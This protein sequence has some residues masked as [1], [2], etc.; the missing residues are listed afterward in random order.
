MPP[1]DRP[2]PSL[3][4]AGIFAAYLVI[5]VALTYP[6]IT[7]IGTGVPNDPADPVLNTW[8]LW[9][10]AV[11]VPLTSAWWNAPA[12]F[13]T[14]GALTLSEHLLG[15]SP[16][17]TPV[18]WLT[19]NIQLGYNLALFLSFPLSAFF[20]YL[21]CLDLTGRR[22]AA[23]IGGLIF[24]FAPYRIVQLPHI[25][26]LCSYWMP[27]ALLGLHR[28]LR[29]ERPRWLVLFGAGWLMQALCNGYYL[30]FLSV[31]IG[32]WI[33]WFVPWRRTRLLLN[34]GVTWALAALPL[35]PI[36]MTYRQV[37][38]DLGLR[39]HIN[40]MLLYS[41]DITSLLDRSPRLLFWQW[42]PTWHRA[43]GEL[44]P[45][46]TAILVIALGLWLVRPRVDS[47]ATPG[48]RRVRNVLTVVAGVA[49]AAVTVAIVRPFEFTLLGAKLS[50]TNIHKPLTAAL[51]AVVAL[52]ATNPRVVRARQQ[53]S[54]LAF[55]VLAAVLMWLFSLGPKPTFMGVQALYRGPYD[56]LL[57]LPGLDT[58]RTPA[59]FHMVTVLCLSCAAAMA[60]AR[61]ATAMR[62]ARVV[63]LTAAVSV[64][65]LADTWI[66]GFPIAAA[67][68]PWPVEAQLSAGA[69]AALPLGTIVGDAAAMY[70]SMRTG[71]PVVNGYSGHR[72]PTYRAVELG[73][74]LQDPDLLAELG[75]QGVTQLALD[76]S[77]DGGA[78]WERYLS[79][80]PDITP[81]AADG[82]HRL[83]R[84]PPVQP[85]PVLRFGA[86]LRPA[87][88]TASVVPDLVPLMTDGNV[89]TRWETGAQRGNEEIVI[90]M[91]GPQR[92]AGI[93]LAVG[94]Q[95]EYI[96]RELSIELSND[97][98]AWAPAWRGSS[99]GPA[100]RAARQDVVRM[101]ITFHLGDH[102]TRFIR[103]RQLGREV[104]QHWSVAELQVLAPAER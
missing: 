55:Y 67:P 64:L 53:R 20:A 19:G 60:F 59:R 96:P 80:R 65:A 48:R 38:A 71:Q 4:G 93:V 21:L 5:A 70:R 17:S 68:R 54:T 23:F 37:H 73:L 92:V 41:A 86:E 94:A 101:P 44:F 49:L 13:P 34:I 89:M 40:E 11:T 103:L 50:V 66:V 102:V 27:V 14:D 84:L 61:L 52:V 22:D 28:Y 98:I 99:A 77:A 29:D 87:A 9:W 76:T 36:V 62:G 35:L 51:L 58:L 12:F 83:Y 100:F 26:V 45:G 3:R 78:E 10:N 47:V 63:A 7:E 75:R 6:L 32:C 33:V 74:S 31:L 69:V 82:T 57:H 97:G 30:V 85:A 42:L 46:V 90:D 72:P 79:G 104:F 2:R 15:L 18:Y 1:V 88:I 95:P 25:Q 39:R 43:E 91:G 81:V 8:I 24:G 56:L 16:I